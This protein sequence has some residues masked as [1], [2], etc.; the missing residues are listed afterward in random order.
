METD[1]K[2]RPELTR[3]IHNSNMIIHMDGRIQEVKNYAQMYIGE[4]E[5]EA[6]EVLKTIV[7]KLDK[8]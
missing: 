8:I 5:S 2:I 1:I 4:F 6:D 7:E 3:E